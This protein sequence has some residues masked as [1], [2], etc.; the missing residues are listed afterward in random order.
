MKKIQWTSEFEVGIH[1]IDT[2]H[3]ILFKLL[4]DL[5]NA[6]ENSETIDQAVELSQEVFK[7]LG[8]YIEIHFRDE[9]KIMKDNGWPKLDEHINSHRKFEARVKD[10][11]EAFNQTEN[12]L[13]PSIITFLEK[14]LIKHIKGT[15]VEIG[16]F[17]KDKG[18]K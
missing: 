17:L 8:E 16:I 18:L 12:I 4:N 3:K 1:H 7:N 11:S 2:Q 13:F 6:T 14:W 9:E 10:L 15:D 5:Y